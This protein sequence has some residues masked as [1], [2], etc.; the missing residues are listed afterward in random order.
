MPSRPTASGAQ[1]WRA[2]SSRRLPV[3]CT[4]T[5][6]R[7]P[8]RT[9][10]WR[11]GLHPLLLLPTPPHLLLLLLRMLQLHCRRSSVL[12]PA[13]ST[14]V[15]VLSRRSAPEL[16][17]RA[18]R[19]RTR[20]SSADDAETPRSSGATSAPRGVG[21]GERSR[22]GPKTRSPAPTSQRA[23]SRPRRPGRPRP[24]RV[25]R[26]CSPRGQLARA[27]P[28]RP[29]RGCVPAEPAC[30]SAG[31]ETRRRTLTRRSR[32]R[33]LRRRHVAARSLSSLAGR[34]P[35]IRK[36]R[37]IQGCSGSAVARRRCSPARP[38]RR[39]AP[40]RTSY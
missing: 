3:T 31:S 24:L 23:V 2:A 28:L 4:R 6:A 38:P 20:R 8:A 27:G 22:R 37:P 35:P 36:R 14:R 30:C 18:V 39:A 34:P 7:T 16:R 15:T 12:Q 33:R 25:S 9:R 29:R 32:S 19:K 1:S 40:R 13:K 26:R 21:T 5:A 10:R 17:T 11:R